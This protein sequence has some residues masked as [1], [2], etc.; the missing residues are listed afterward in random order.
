MVLPFLIGTFMVVLMFQA[1]QLIALYKDQNINMQRVPFVA[2]LQFILLKTPSWLQLTMPVGIALG[3]SLS[4]SRIARESELTA[5]RSAGIPIRR[6][7]VPVLIAGVFGAGLNYWITEHLMPRSERASTKLLGEMGQLALQPT[8]KSNVSLSLNGWIVTI[9]TVTRG[10]GDTMNMSN[11]M[12]AQ[13]D[14][15]GEETVVIADQGSYRQGN[16]VF[17]LATV[18]V[19]KGKDLTQ[20]RTKSE[21]RINQRISVENF[22]GGSQTQEMS[23]PELRA[24][25]AAQREAKL[26]PRNL[27]IEFYLRYSLPASCAIFAFTGAVLAVSFARNGPFV[28]VMLTFVLVMVY[29]NA[30]VI[31]KE[32]IGRN[33][34]L[35]PIAAAWTP[36]VVFLLLGLWM[37]RRAE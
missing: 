34:Y 5:I 18:R 11:V 13:K 24:A 31:A 32:I 23:I 2:V 16:W 10:E 7:L 37:L 4:L 19:F 22:F 26:D 20:I 3:A 25:I 29:Y 1:N 14:S 9:G 36:N 33:G 28:G 30:F 17:P 21:M 12:L 35:P 27:E 15:R 6:V 8:F